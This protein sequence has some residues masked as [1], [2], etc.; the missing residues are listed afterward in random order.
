MPGQGSE[1][2]SEQLLVRVPGPVVYLAGEGH[3]RLR[4][5]VAAWKQHHGAGRLDMW[6]SKTGTDLNTP[7]GYQRVVDAIRA[8][9]YPPSLINVAL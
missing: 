7:E 3:H 6:I 8:L 9:P 4:S 5:R 2:L 1:P